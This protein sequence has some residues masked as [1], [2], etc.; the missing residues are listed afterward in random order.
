MS[1]EADELYFIGFALGVYQHDGTQCASSQAAL[2]VGFLQLYG[3]QF[4]EGVH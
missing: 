3:I 1:V 4:G 2:G